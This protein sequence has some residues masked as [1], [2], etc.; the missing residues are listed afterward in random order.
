[1][2]HDDIDL[3][4]DRFRDTTD[5]FL[6]DL[7]FEPTLLIRTLLARCDLAI[8]VSD[9]TTEALTG[10]KSTVT[11]MRFLG[12]PLKRIAA[13]ITD[14]VGTFPQK[15]LPNSKAH[16][17]P[18]IAVSVWGMT[19]YAAN[20]P[21]A[22]SFSKPPIILSHPDCPM[23]CAI[24]ELAQRIITAEIKNDATRDVVKRA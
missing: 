21:T 16:I 7:P 10:V 17:D 9:Q 22:P 11:A 5:F 15:E 24:K 12:I 18:T 19:P 1:M 23:A 8:I 13:V 2:K 3:P 4:F 6:V 20:A 14:P